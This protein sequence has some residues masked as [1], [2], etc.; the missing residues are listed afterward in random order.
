MNKI[1]I[2]KA[3]DSWC[4]W[5]CAGKKCCFGKLVWYIYSGVQSCSEM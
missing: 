1:L 2:K 3:P 4:T 5:A